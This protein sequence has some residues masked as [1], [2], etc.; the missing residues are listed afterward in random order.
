MLLLYLFLSPLIMAVVLMASR[1]AAR[2]F[3]V[4]FGMALL[5]NVISAVVLYAAPQT[6]K[7]VTLL[8]DF[9]LIGPKSSLTLVVDGLSAPF[10]LLTVILTA[11]SCLWVK[12]WAHSRIRLA[13][14]MMVDFC[15][16]GVF[17]VNDLVMLFMFFELALIPMFFIIGWWGSDQR[18]YAA[19]KFFLYTAAGSAFMLAAIIY[20][21]VSA[22]SSNI[23]LAMQRV[24]T[25]SPII[26]H[27][28]WW[29]LFIGFAIKVPMIPLHSW[30]PDA[31][32]QAPTYGSSM[33]AGV[34]IKMGAYGFI[35]VLLPMFP[36][37]CHYYSNMIFIL[38]V[39]AV[40]YTSLVALAQDEMKKVIAYSSIAHMGFVTIGIFSGTDEGIYG[41][42]FQ[43]ISHG[44]V[45]AALF[46]CVGHIYECSKSKLIKHFSGLAV[47][48]PR[49]AVWFTV[50]VMAS[51]GLPGTSGFIGEYL[52]IQGIMHSS[53]VYAAMLATSVVLG[54]CYM[55]SL[56]RS[57]IKGPLIDNTFTSSLHD[58]RSKE[59]LIMT[60]MSI[61][62]LSLG[63]YPDCVMHIFRDHASCIQSLIR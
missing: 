4:L 24:G 2:W 58:F 23:N 20:I 32:V 48:M 19:F 44:I 53:F 31:H 43:M 52:V 50:F 29:A 7:P 56:H 13:M 39:I 35:R 6:W 36:Q 25:Y 9:T 46:F 15:S 62:V 63:L 18:K 21:S 8:P 49:F 30:L 17:V 37:L 5:S 14:L 42:L 10:I 51:V 40:I 33:L 26:S 1:R 41:A 60:I 16:V 55:L 61:I 3:D 57:L 38:S 27:I 54:A 22:G 59:L 45:S 11:L 28:L 34:L 12:D 47:V